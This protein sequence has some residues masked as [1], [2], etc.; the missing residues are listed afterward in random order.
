MG[1]MADYALDQM[2]DLDEVYCQ[3]L[4]YG[5]DTDEE[6]DPILSP[7][8]HEPGSRKQFGLGPCPNCGGKTIIREGPYGF[9][10]GCI[11]FPKCRGTR[12]CEEQFLPRKVKKLTKTQ[13]ITYNLLEV[14]DRF[15]FKDDKSKHKYMITDMTKKSDYFNSEEK[16]AISLSTGKTITCRGFEEDTKIICTKRKR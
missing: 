7:F 12:K 16:I 15:Y 9:F 14:G 3:S 5:I 11:K 13:K 2:M 10:Y 1:D 4:E 8:H 6:G